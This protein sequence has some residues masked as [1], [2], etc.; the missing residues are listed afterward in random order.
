MLNF[1]LFL[2]IDFLYS[3]VLQP[4]S[5]PQY[6]Y[7]GYAYKKGVQYLQLLPKVDSNLRSKTI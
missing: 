4:K 5:Q 3:I 1:L 7:N 2:P 6:T